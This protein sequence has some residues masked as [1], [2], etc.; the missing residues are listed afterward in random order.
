MSTLYN[1]YLKM[2]NGASIA[3]IGMIAD[4]VQHAI[5][6][7]IADATERTGCQVYDYDYEEEQFA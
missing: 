7:A 6:M 5:G 2:E 3:S 4:D 1:V